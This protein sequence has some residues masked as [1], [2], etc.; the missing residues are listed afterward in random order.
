MALKL[1][2]FVAL[3]A[4][5]SAIV[6]PNHQS[7]KH[8]SDPL[9]RMELE[10]LVAQFAPVSVAKSL[11]KDAIYGSQSTPQGNTLCTSSLY[12]TPEI[13]FGL[14][15]GQLGETVYSDFNVIGFSSVIV[16][17]AS[18]ATF[19]GRVLTKM[20][21]SSAGLADIGSEIHITPLHPEPYGLVAGLVN[22]PTGVIGAGEEVFAGEPGAATVPAGVVIGG[23]CP[24][25]NCLSLPIDVARA[26][27]LVKYWEYYTTTPNVKYEL[28]TLADGTNVLHLIADGPHSN[29]VT[30]RIPQSVWNIADRIVLTKFPN[31][32]SCKFELAVLIGTDT[33]DVL[34]R[35]DVELPAD[36]PTK[37]TYV[38][39]P[40][41]GFPV[42]PAAVVTGDVA[43]HI[44]APLGT[45]NIMSGAT[46]T[47]Y[48]IGETVVNGGIVHPPA[49]LPGGNVWRV[50]CQKDN[51]F[52]SI[53]EAIDNQ[54]VV[55]GDTIQICPGAYAGNITIYKAVDLVGC[56]DDKC[57]PAATTTYQTL[58]QFSNDVM[59][60]DHLS[61]ERLWGSSEPPVEAQESEKDAPVMSV[62]NNNNKLVGCSGSCKKPKHSGPAVKPGTT[63]GWPSVVVEVQAGE[64]CALVQ[65]SGASI[66]NIVF[67]MK[68]P[69]RACIVVEDSVEDTKIYHNDFRVLPT[70]AGVLPSFNCSCE[71]GAIICLL[72]NAH[73]TG[74]EANTFRGNDIAFA[75][76]VSEQNYQS[77]I[78]DNH[79]FIHSELECAVA[80]L[81]I[82]ASGV[83][84]ETR[85]YRFVVS[86]N[87]FLIGGHHI[88][89]IASYALSSTYAFNIFKGEEY[90]I[91]LWASSQ[92]EMNTTI[93]GNYFE[94]QYVGVLLLAVP[95]ATAAPA[96]LFIQR[97]SFR[98]GYAGIALDTTHIAEIDQN[99]F[100]NFERGLY[101]YQSFR[102]EFTRNYVSTTT[103]AG[104]DIT[105][106]L[107]LLVAHNKI[108]LSGTAAAVSATQDPE[109]GVV[110]SETYVLNN[111][112]EQG[113]GD[114]LYLSLAEAGFVKVANNYVSDFLNEGIDILGTQ[115]T[116]VVNNQVEESYGTGIQIVQPIVAVAPTLKRDISSKEVSHNNIKDSWINGL[117]LQATQDVLVEENTIQRSFKHGISASSDCDNFISI[118]KSKISQSLENGA[119]LCG[120]NNVV[121]DSSI[122][123]SGWCSVQSCNTVIIQNTHQDKTCTQGL[124]CAECISCNVTAVAE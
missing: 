47:G 43:G 51:D 58:M 78:T 68:G 66:H 93:I 48:V 79:Y 105:A 34:F 94:H 5:V 40:S 15:L 52:F 55:D 111:H 121:S 30:E 1:L 123:S 96:Y 61:L 36:C 35:P 67:L 80:A 59:E 63:G 21:D 39:L 62:D 85:V 112:L 37:V 86:R 91:E 109:A 54:K 102:L 83:F 31:K 41:Y 7:G 74:I 57:S 99:C 108:V 92:G 69:D 84:A 44:L 64:N 22:W 2:T 11:I 89:G 45:I 122:K 29:Y 16:P 32:H 13:F 42:F 50:G 101:A 23:S 116:E 110:N 103:Y 49:C 87:E 60:H 100:Q 75:V 71:T 124:N 70:D 72:P 76:Y 10:D 119:S 107:F 77:H 27:Y 20:F 12:Y 90:G 28:E 25:L 46:V 120:E 82:V 6:L 118:S 53:Q 65:T 18:N 24:G 26:F 98:N 8:V 38:I 114:G 73:R 88:H 19:G 81:P 4:A 117:H 9:R 113:A 104:A 17:A 97:N 115:R 14:P 3:L 56:N 106:Y 95:N 33:S